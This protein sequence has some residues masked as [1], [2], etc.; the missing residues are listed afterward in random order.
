MGRKRISEEEIINDAAQ[1][2]AQAV[3]DAQANGQQQQNEAPKES[4]SDKW[5][6]LANRRA[7]RAIKDIRSLIPLAS[8]G[9]YEYTEEHAQ[10]LVAV[11]YEALTEVKR[12]YEGKR[13]ANPTVLFR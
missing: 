8:K 11:L 3:A 12:A 10:M 13:Q 5:K 6:R 2:G 4:K 1:E 7:A 9:Q